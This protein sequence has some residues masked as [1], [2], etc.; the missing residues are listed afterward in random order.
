MRDILKYWHLGDMGLRYD[1]DTDSGAVGLILYPRQ[2]QSSLASKAGCRID[3]LVQVKLLGDDYPKGFLHGKSL[4]NGGTTLGL[5]LLRQYQ[6][7]M[8]H[9]I[10]IVTE[11]TDS[12][13]NHYHHY[14]FWRENAQSLKVW[15]R[16]TN[17]QSH[18][19]TLEMISSFS[20]GGFSPWHDITPVGQLWLT[21]FRSKWTMEGREERHQVEEYQL[22]SCWKPSGGSC[23][24]FGQ[25]GSMPVRGFFPAVALEDESRNVAWAAQ[26]EL[27]SSWQ[28]EVYSKEQ[29][30]ALSG[31]LADREFGHWMKRVL[32]GESFTT[33]AA[34]VTVCAGD[35]YAA[36]Q[37][38][39]EP[40]SGEAWQ[41][42]LSRNG[43]LPVV[44]NEFCTSWGRPAAADISRTLSCLRGRDID[45][46]VIDA[47]WYDE[48]AR[49]WSLSHGDWKPAEGL[50]PEGMG[51][52]VEEIHA[53][54][55]KAGIWFEIETVGR[56]SQ[57]FRH[58]TWLL[59][60]DG[61]PLTVGDRRFWDMRSP[62]VI[63]FLTE[64]VIHFLQH[65][66][67]DYLK[68]DYNENI[69]IGIDHTD[70]PGEGLRQVIDAS[71]DFFRAIRRQCPD[72]IV[73]NCAS[74]GH[75][76][77][78]ATR[79]LADIS[80]FSDAHETLCI[81]VVAA[82]LHFLLPPATSLIWAVF[83]EE[84]DYRRLVYSLCATF[85]GRVC[86]SGDVEKLTPAQWRY[87]DSGLAF[88]RQLR[89]ILLDGVSERHGTVVLSYDHPTGYQVVV[90][91]GKT[92]ARA[93]VICHSFSLTDEQKVMRISIPLTP[94][95]WRLAAEFQSGGYTVALE[96]H[97]LIL[98]PTEDFSAIALNLIRTAPTV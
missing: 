28:L 59:H 95:H 90:R 2:Y 79:H 15:T 7:E 76:L 3:S 33:P 20:L 81:P 16:F 68:I 63:N 42:W 27:A 57:S 93:M 80:S 14:V 91:Y 46:Y 82:N 18:P 78:A 48:D 41:R 94:G 4:R 38:L 52:V 49:Q 45:Y 85:L 55:M 89:E 25:V 30:I 31:G 56:W 60:R 32:P 73:E 8:P 11:L 51:A 21:R 1:T 96:P 12:R 72:L 88:Y 61:H 74:G 37:R 6:E 23:E 58:T 43:D 5:S 71:Q 86:L 9:G 44:F 19:E 83:R 54:G 62:D 87:I 47:G 98:T 65:H 40:E 34:R 92:A 39:L 35:R 22:E 67:F 26:L 66:R 70:S 75:R 77:D 10:A 97:R 13:G 64:K 36:C 29:D 69:G 24:K 53:H 50:F 17:R 84:D